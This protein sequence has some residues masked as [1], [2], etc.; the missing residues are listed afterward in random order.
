MGLTAEAAEDSPDYQIP[1]G[2]CSWAGSR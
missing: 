1:V 2:Q